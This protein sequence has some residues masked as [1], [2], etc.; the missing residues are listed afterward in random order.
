MKVIL[1][2]YYVDCPEWWKKMTAGLSVQSIQRELDKY[3][4]TIG[5]GPTMQTS[6]LNFPDEQT[7]LLVVLRWS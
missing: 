6:T 5:P 4:C 2:V 1:P 3:N 7:Y